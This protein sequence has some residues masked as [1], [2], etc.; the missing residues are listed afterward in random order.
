MSYTV[1]VAFK[2]RKDHGCTPARPADDP[3]AGGP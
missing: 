1:I 3:H 2:T